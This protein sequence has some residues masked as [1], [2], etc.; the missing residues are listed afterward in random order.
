M[1]DLNQILKK[2]SE[3]RHIDFPNLL[4][5]TMKCE[6]IKALLTSDK[7]VFFTSEPKIREGIYQTSRDSVISFFTEDLSATE[8]MMILSKE[9][10]KTE[11]VIDAIKATSK[12]V[13]LVLSYGRAKEKFEI[14]RSRVDEGAIYPDRKEIEDL[15]TGKKLTILTYQPE[16]RVCDL[17]VP[18]LDKLELM[19][20]M[21]V[22]EEL[23]DVLSSD[24]LDGLKLFKT[25]EKMVS[26]SVLK[27]GKLEGR[28]ERFKKYRNNTFLKKK[29]KAYL[30]VNREME[31]KWEDVY[32]KIMACFSPLIE[33][34]IKNEVFLD[35]WM[36]ELGRFLA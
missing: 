34:H 3:E 1:N 6:L 31:V 28:Y 16:F 4:F 11:F 24:P 9:L 26:E 5:Y 18:I 32:D 36:P 23:Y 33:A 14:I 21:E 29:W 19:N 22:Y 15:I 17:I 8:I 10:E 35:S 27:D 13:T 7:S 2:I 12:K 25:F 30:R 20:D